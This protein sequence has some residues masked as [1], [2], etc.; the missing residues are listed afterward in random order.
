MKICHVALYTRDLESIK[1]FYIKYFNGK[2]NEIYQDKATGFSSYFITFESGAALE[3]MSMSN[4]LKD[5]SKDELNAGYSHM[6]FSV[7]DREAVDCLTKKL[8]SDGFEVVSGPRVT[9]DGYYE[10][11]VLDPDKNRVEITCDNKISFYHQL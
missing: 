6:A 11:C 3:I 4:G 1:N 10:S 2:S 9:G 7:G 5:V 8:K